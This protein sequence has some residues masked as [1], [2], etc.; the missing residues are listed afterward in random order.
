M[1]SLRD[2]LIDVGRNAY[3]LGE[4]VAS[5]G[6]SAIA[7]PVA[8]YAAMFDPVNGAQ[9]IREGMT[10]QPRTEAGRMYQ[11][12]AAQAVG[13][14]V[15]PV[16]P[17]VDTWQ[18]GVDIAG[19]YSPTLGALMQTAP[20]AFGVALGAKPTLQAGR[21][22]SNTLGAMQ[23]RMIA[24]ANAPRTLNTGFMG[25]RGI[26][27]GINAL[28]ADKDA[29]A[30]AQ[31]MIAQGV[32]P[33]DVWKETGWGRGA[34]GKWRFEIDDSKIDLQD[35]H[36]NDVYFIEDAIGDNPITKAYPNIKDN[37]LNIGRLDNN[38]RGY[39]GMIDAAGDIALNRR[40]TNEGNIKTEELKKTLFH[41]LQHSIQAKEGFAKGGN[42]ETF[43]FD[44]Y[45]KLA[46]EVE[47]RTTESR[48]KLNAQQ[49]RENYPFDY[50]VWG[51]DVPSESQIV[52]F[53]SNK[54]MS[55]R[56]LTEFEQ[57]HLIAQ[58]NA[59]LPVSQGG[60]GLAP[61]N[62]AM[63]R[64]RAMG[65]DVDNP[66][67]HGTNWDFLEF[68]RVG[69]KANSLGLG[70]YTTPNPKK[71]EMYGDRIMPLLTKDEGVLDWGNLTNEQRKEISINL[72]DRVPNEDMAGYAPLS[73]KQFPKT[74]EGTSEAKTFFREKQKETS[75]YFHDR[76]KPKI[77]DDGEHWA[78]EWRDPTNIDEANNQEL[79]NL[80][81]RFDPDIANAL[82]YKGAKFGD[83]TAI[84]N[85]KNIRS[86]FAAFDPMK[87]E[88]SN[89]LA[90]F[91]A[92]APTATMAAYLYNQERNKGGKQ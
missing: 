41:E 78:I 51:Y 49:R 92:L 23:A 24:N 27:A 19:R 3:G 77:I 40:L 45:K 55:Q 61:D 71:A 32:D 28:T 35:R 82:G 30:K 47:A 91:G 64:A 62:T 80:S 85:P 17:V 42:L 46:G 66:V 44:D 86:R 16:M 37:Y 11:Q 38:I 79:L 63:D 69:E 59:A 60:L 10:Y 18:Q 43:S 7:E 50:R 36:R 1:G 73:K 14:A 67:Y 57:A 25:Q 76:A 22:A 89:L 68:N 88:S 90:Q 58:R 4:N 52:D 20:T 75:N 6:S 21:Q 33:E 83:E 84:F 8:G 34:D 70:H 87:K 74:K 31:Q 48:L 13:K 81:Q 12:G 53:G 56:P 15:K 65:F 39:D 9:A 29:L 26:F 54:A 5:L 2:F 72:K